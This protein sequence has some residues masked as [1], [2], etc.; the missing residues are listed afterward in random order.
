MVLDFDEFLYTPLDVKLYFEEAE[1]AGV[2]QI[3]F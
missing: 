1:K 2:P 3:S